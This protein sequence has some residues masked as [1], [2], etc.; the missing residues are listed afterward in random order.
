MK[1]ILILLFS[2]LVSSNLFSQYLTI[3]PGE[4]LSNAA[5]LCDS[6]SDSVVYNLN[7]QGDFV[8]FGPDYDCLDS[9]PN[10]SWFYIKTT[11]YDAN[12]INI[13]IDANYDLDFVVW[14]PFQDMTYNY[15]SLQADHIVDC[16]Y[17]A[18]SM[19]IININPVSLDSYYIVMITNYSGQA[20]NLA[21]SITSGSIECLP[22]YNFT[23][24][25]NTMGTVYYDE[26]TNCSNDLEYGIP[27]LLLKFSPGDFYALTNDT[28]FYSL[29]LPQE[30]YTSEVIGMYGIMDSCF[31]D[32]IHI[33]NASSSYNFDRGIQALNND[34][35]VSVYSAS[36]YSSN[37]VEPAGRC[38]NYITFNNNTPNTSNGTLEVKLDAIFHV[39]SA[40]EAYFQIGDSILVFEYSDLLF[41]ESRTIEIISE[42]IINLEYLNYEIE[43]FVQINSIE[44]DV[45]L[46]NNSD[47]SYTIVQLP[48]DPNNISAS[49]YG[50]YEENSILIEDTFITYTINFQ[51][52]GSA[53]AHN[54]N[55]YDSVPP[56]LDIESLEF[57]TSSH[58]CQ[59]FF[60]EDN[61]LRFNFQGIEL[62]DS[63]H[64]EPESH[65][66]VIFRLE[67]SVL[68]NVGDEIV[69]FADIYFDN[70]PAVRTNEVRSIV[71]SSVSI[72]ELNKENIQIYPN[73][74][75]DII[76]I[77]I[78]SND[79]EMLVDVFS[80]GGQLVKTKQVYRNNIQIPV[81]DLEKGLYLVRVKT[82]SK[83]YTTKVM[84]Y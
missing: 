59:I 28:G 3:P 72:Q 76:N 68:L 39:Y 37:L 13:T 80:V 74:A 11:D 19:T 54:V 44:P 6:Y 24:E 49:P 7:Y 79:E 64:N 27:N 69:N 17:T 35:D 73:P 42:P 65:G 43:N 12:P 23:E 4:T 83:V 38:R 63:L 40:S 1:K 14:G 18:V 47:Y 71:T 50:S 61:T 26:N 30:N 67:T 70:N 25:V 55:L 58:D 31:L 84:V 8:E 10:P 9:Q 51:N 52:T 78:P 34:V 20:I 45:N 15:D 41:N 82:N 21:P 48:E 33:I 57:I 32:T 56:E 16:E 2:I 36:Y 60:E 66:F 22:F 53:P 81:G 29:Y 75:K 46:P 62:M 5:P 77:I